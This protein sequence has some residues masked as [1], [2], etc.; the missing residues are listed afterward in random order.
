M[1]VTTSLR[2][3]YGLSRCVKDGN[4][5]FLL[6]ANSFFFLVLISMVN[7]Y[8]EIPQQGN[9]FISWLFEEILNYKMI[10]GKRK[11]FLSFSHNIT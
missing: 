4:F 10:A 3:F 8:L 1:V 2:G 9:C 6:I 7:V 11:Y 5:S